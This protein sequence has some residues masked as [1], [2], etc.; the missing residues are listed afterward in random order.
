[1]RRVDK[2]SSALLHPESAKANE[3]ISSFGRRRHLHRFPCARRKSAN[4]D[5]L[6]RCLRK[7]LGSMPEEERSTWYTNLCTEK[8]RR[9]T[10]ITAAAPPV[11]LKPDDPKQ[12][13]SR[14]E[15][16]QSRKEKPQSR[17]EKPQGQGNNTTVT[18]Q[19][20]LERHSQVHKELIGS[21]GLDPQTKV[22]N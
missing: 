15:K 12:P 19:Q 6:G 18:H 3:Y 22:I 20:I 10:A 13:P 11:P 2:L 7:D 17:E 9:C 5:G 1:M 16:P 21:R 4:G 8:R 14:K